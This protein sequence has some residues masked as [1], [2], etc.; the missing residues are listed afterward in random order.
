[1]NSSQQN[2]FMMQV[3]HIFRFNKFVYPGDYFL[4]NYKM[5]KCMVIFCMNFLIRKKTVIGM[6]GRENKSKS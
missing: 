4:F 5:I 3:M 2:K 1:M 6:C